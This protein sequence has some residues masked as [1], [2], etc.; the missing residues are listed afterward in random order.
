MNLVLLLIIIILI[1]NCFVF[2]KYL[3]PIFG[4]FGTLPLISAVVSWFGGSSII[5][6]IIRATLSFA[7]TIVASFS[8]YYIGYNKGYDDAVNNRNRSWIASIWRWFRAGK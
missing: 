1:Q 7:T 4:W 2:W 5:A 3:K 6:R 8:G